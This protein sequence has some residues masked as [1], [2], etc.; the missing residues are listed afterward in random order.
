MVDLLIR[1]H[2]AFLHL[3]LIENL[4]SVIHAGNVLAQKE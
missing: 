4:I 3:L 2:L 1:Q